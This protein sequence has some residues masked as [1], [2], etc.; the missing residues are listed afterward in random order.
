VSLAKNTVLCRTLGLQ[1]APRVKIIHFTP[2]VHNILLLFSKQLLG[3]HWGDSKLRMDAGKGIKGAWISVRSK[4]L[5]SL[6][7]LNSA[8]KIGNVNIFPKRI[9]FHFLHNSKYKLFACFIYA[10]HLN[11]AHGGN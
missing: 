10:I 3:S 7:A 1:T 5:S 6:D 11:Q 8:R 4:N 2:W 9:F